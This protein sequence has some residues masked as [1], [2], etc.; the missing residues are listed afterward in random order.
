MKK[1]VQIVKKQSLI[2]K[3]RKSV[4]FWVAGASILIGALVVVCGIFVQHLMFNNKVIDTQKKT[5]ATIAQ[6]T[7]QVNE[8]E[9]DL[10]VKNTDEQ[11]MQARSSSNA[12]A[13]QTVLDALPADANRLALGASLEQKIFNNI[14]GLDV[15]SLSVDSSTSSDGESGDI[16][17]LGTLTFSATISG[18]PDALKL[19]L[20]RAERSIR[21]LSIQTINGTSSSGNVTFTITGVAYYLQPVDLSLKQTEVH[22]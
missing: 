19:G 1:D 21:A 2:D 8:L 11:L 5:I 18:T 22:S 3:T 12:E 9:A 7:K 6:N 13:L 14:P 15:Q 4:I 16:E 17:G 20:Q 10:R